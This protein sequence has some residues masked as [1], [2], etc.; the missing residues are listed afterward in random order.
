MEKIFKK[1]IIASVVLL[2]LAVPL[3]LVYPDGYLPENLQ[4]INDANDEKLFSGF[5]LIFW[6]SFLI[7][8]FVSYYLIYKFK[9]I[10]RTLFLICVLV[11]FPYL[12]L[13]G[14]NVYHP[15]DSMVEYLIAMI[16][17]ALLLLMY[18]SPLKNRFS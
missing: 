10:G 5:G 11:S 3:A 15:F 6:V 16:D 1:L 2:V 12:Y 7:A 17:G 14:N 9:K 8:I 4:A 13:A 18:A